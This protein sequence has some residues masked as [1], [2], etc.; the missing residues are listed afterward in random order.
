MQAILALVS[1]LIV[2]VLF[3]ALKLP[4]P[5]PPTLVGILGIVGIY[6]GFQLYTMLSQFF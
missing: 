1:G 4:L 5:A 2:G 6:L 3:S